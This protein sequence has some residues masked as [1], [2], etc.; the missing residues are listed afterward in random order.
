LLATELT[1]QQTLL[2]KLR[3]QILQEAIEGKLTADWRQQ[4]P[5]VEPASELL[6]RIQEEKA[7]LIK[8]KKIKTQTPLPPIREEEKPF[9]LP[10]GWQWCRLGDISINSLGKMLDSQK[11][12]G[13]LKPYLRNLNVQWFKVNIS[14]LKQMP[15]EDHETQKY[16]VLKGDI[17]ICEGGYPGQA[18]IWEKNTPIMFQKALHRVRFISEC[19][20]SIL[21]VNI[22]WLW[23]ANGEIKK[24]FTGAGIQHLTGKSLNKML[25]PLPPFSEQKAIVVK[26]EK[27]LSLCDQLEAQITDNQTHAEQL[28]QAV[29]RETFSQTSDQ[30]SQEAT[31]A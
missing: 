13:E 14:D 20:S 3:Q 4:T 21:F 6:A 16:S 26:V 28:M 30:Q 11:N 31:N 25:I 23:D 1:H 22:L 29:L 15:F 12:K 8:D 27:L 5:E 18:A 17:V 7:Q 19:F 2:K 10:E 24:Y 9:A